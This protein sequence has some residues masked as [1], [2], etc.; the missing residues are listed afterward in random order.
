VALR[1]WA[2]VLRHISLRLL[3]GAFPRAKYTEMLFLSPGR[4]LLL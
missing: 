3:A 1:V 4:M 2:S